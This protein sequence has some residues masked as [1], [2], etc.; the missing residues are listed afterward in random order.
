VEPNV[1]HVIFYNWNFTSTRYHE[2]VVGGAGSVQQIWLLC[3]LWFGC[4]R[5]LLVNME[6]GELNKWGKT[7][8]NPPNETTKWSKPSIKG[9]LK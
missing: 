7:T 3:L 2:L 4:G 5:N 1:G 6:W 8:E 9:G